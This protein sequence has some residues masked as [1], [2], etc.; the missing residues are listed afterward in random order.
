MFLAS[1]LS[2]FAGAWMFA[3]APFTV[4]MKSAG[5]SAR[6]DGET[7][8]VTQVEPKS[9]AAEAGLQP[10]MKVKRIDM[11]ARA[12][13]KVPLAQLDATDLQDALTPQ[14]GESLWLKVER[15]KGT[16][17]V[18]LQSRE[19]LPDH[20]FPS[21]PLTQAQLE[22]LTPMQLGLYHARLQQAVLEEHERP[23]FDAMQDTTAYV[24]QGKLVGVEGG[25]A[26]PLW[27][28]PRI[29]LQATCLT[30]VESVELV[31]TAKGV[32]RTLGPEDS[33]YPGTKTFDLTP[34]LWPVPRVLQQCEGAPKPLEQSLRIKLT[35]KGKP[36]L[37]RDVAMKLAVRC[38]VPSPVTLRPLDLREPWDFMV[39]DKTPLQVDVSAHQLIPRPTEAT[40][41]EVD[42][43]GRVTRRLMPLPLGRN[44][45][46]SSIPVKVAL[47]TTV[48]RTARLALE[49]R[50]SDG[51]TWISEPRTRD[52]R[53]QAQREADDREAVEAH[54]KLEAFG[55][56]LAAKFPEPC[57][58]LPATMKWLEAQPDLEYASS[59]EDGHSFAYKVKGALAPLIFSCH[60]H[61]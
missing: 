5:Y 58:D 49:A 47:D 38:N 36:P 4:T 56:R 50:F 20:P 53:S 14:P 52:I 57:A 44:A 17:Q 1:L 28:H 39:G 42:A 3:A 32:R 9:V 15:A 13:I 37:E 27:L 51:S 61:R 10:G 60:R 46:A 29:D 33:R 11:P 59:E 54:A 18:V 23:R 48:A 43:K 31:S 41:V 34:A 40:L 8:T 35:C 25:G 24:M 21:V 6:S 12:F 45:H 16:T 2:V 7:V 26:T 55:K 22:R 30:G 19:P